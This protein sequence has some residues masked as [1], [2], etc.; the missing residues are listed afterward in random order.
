MLCEISG[1]DTGSKGHSKYKKRES[2]S[3]LMKRFYYVQ[4]KHDV[5]MTT[6][7]KKVV[8]MRK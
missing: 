4:N 3:K 5:M 8:G 7:K 1:R 6:L 2:K